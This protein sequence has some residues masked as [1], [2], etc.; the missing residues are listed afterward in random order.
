MVQ[1]LDGDKWTTHMFHMICMSNNV[2]EE[3]TDSKG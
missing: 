2:I 1:T 3:H